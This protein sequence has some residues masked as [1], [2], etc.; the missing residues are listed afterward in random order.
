MDPDPSWRRTAPPSANSH[1][2]SIIMRMKL[3]VHLSH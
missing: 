1:T 2:P 3:R